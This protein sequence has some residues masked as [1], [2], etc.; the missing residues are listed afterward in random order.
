VLLV[1]DHF[2]I[3]VKYTWLK[4]CVHSKLNVKDEYV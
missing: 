3:A 2:E 1:G 4:Y